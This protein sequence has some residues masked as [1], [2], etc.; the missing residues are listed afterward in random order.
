MKQQDMLRQSMRQSSQTRAQL[1][2]G[3]GI[4]PRTLDKW[5]L[6]ETS[7]DFRRMPE[8]ALRL[9]ASQHG[10]RKSADLSMPYDWP[11]PAMGDDTLILAVLRRARFEDLVRI[12]ANFGIA[13][14]RARIDDALALAPDTERGILTRILTR[15]LRSIEI[16]L[17]QQSSGRTTA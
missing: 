6:P 13:P 3:M 9:L 5:L 14:V 12:C 1:A 4:S 16:A 17:V 15:M 7:G 2:A 8:T 10:L 11:N